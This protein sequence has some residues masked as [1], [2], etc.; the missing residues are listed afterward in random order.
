MVQ[1]GVKIPGK[2]NLDPVIREGEAVYMISEAS[3]PNFNRKYDKSQKAT[4]TLVRMWK[5]DPVITDATVDVDIWV[6]GKDG[7]PTFSVGFLR[8]ML[9]ISAV[10]KNEGGGFYT[11]KEVMD[12]DC[13][14]EKED[15]DGL[16]VVA[17]LEYN[18]K[19]YIDKEKNAHKAVRL[20]SVRAPTVEEGYNV[21]IVPQHYLKRGDDGVVSYEL[22][23]PI[24]P[25][26][27]HYQ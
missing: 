13:V 21:S 5:E 4:V 19:P 10:A 11:P 24:T 12:L 27:E 7:K 1:F 20:V 6:I 3:I 2:R 22:F 18:D 17:D 9:S 8:R 23:A 15:L 25:P 26:E 16:I 14:P